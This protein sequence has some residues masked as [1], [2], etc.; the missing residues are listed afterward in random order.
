MAQEMYGARNWASDEQMCWVKCSEKLAT[1]REK[2]NHIASLTNREYGLSMII[3]EGT[4][5][6]FGHNNQPSS[7]SLESIVS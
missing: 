1:A 2:I 7:S 5:M 3:V 6:N 4:V